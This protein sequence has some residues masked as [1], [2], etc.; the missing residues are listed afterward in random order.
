MATHF[1]FIHIQISPPCQIYLQKTTNHYRSVVKGLQ[2]GAYSTSSCRVSFRPG[3]FLL[4]YPVMSTKRFYCGEKIRRL[5]CSQPF[6]FFLDKR[7]LKLTLLPFF[8]VELERLGEGPGH[9]VEFPELP[10][11]P[12]GAPA[13]YHPNG[14]LFH[15]LTRFLSFRKVRSTYY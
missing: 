9:D 1:Q 11:S 15:P 5:C 8:L 13:K 4:P 6:L 3:V 2:E 14:R 7:S 12:S 10:V